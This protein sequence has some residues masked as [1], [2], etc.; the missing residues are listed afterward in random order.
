LTLPKTIPLLPNELPR[1][2]LCPL[3]A[4]FV[5]TKEV[6]HLFF[7]KDTYIPKEEKSIN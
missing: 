5:L 4:E 7:S 2:A 3:D 1:K 6:T